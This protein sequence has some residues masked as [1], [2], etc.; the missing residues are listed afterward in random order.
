MCLV[1]DGFEPLE[2]GRLFRGMERCGCERTA[3]SSM[4]RMPRKEPVDILSEI[5]CVA[6]MGIFARINIHRNATS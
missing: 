2:S 6:T 4:K 1:F 5:A 3:S